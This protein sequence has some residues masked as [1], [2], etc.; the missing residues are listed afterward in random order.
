MSHLRVAVLAVTALVLL[1]A[2][3][4]LPTGPPRQD[5]LDV[6]LG[7]VA[8]FTLIERS[9]R[10]V[11]N[12]DLRGKIWVASFIFTRCPGE[13]V[14]I[15]R[16]LADLQARLGK[17]NEVT[18]VS[19]TVDP[20]HDTPEVLRAYARQKGA[21]PRRWLFLTGEHDTVLKVIWKSFFQPVQEATGKGKERYVLA[22]SPRLVV[23]DHEGRFRGYVDGTKDEEVERLRHRL[24]WLV[25]EKYQHFPTINAALNGLAGLLLIGG[26]LAIRRRRLVLHKVIMLTAL[27]VSMVF[28]ASYL[29]YHFAILEGRPSGFP[30]EGW[31][32]TVY[33]AVLLSHTVLAAVVAPLALFTAFRGLR[34]QLARHVRI[35]RWTLPLWLYVSVTGVIVYW[36]RYHLYP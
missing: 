20:R 29:Y 36:M 10:P 18:L 12:R 27:A 26:Y 31:V 16:N 14:V 2:A 22:H 19:L 7:P 13:C 4:A 6:D 11:S 17:Q 25:L 5:T 35:A 1:C 21:D 28:L 3:D 8:D 9:G 15:T 32:R 23:I 24:R 30:G 34:N 33:L